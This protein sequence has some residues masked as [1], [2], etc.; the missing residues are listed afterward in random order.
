MSVVI[1]DD[2]DVRRG[3]SV[4]LYLPAWLSHVCLVVGYPFSCM[5]LPIFLSLCLPDCSLASCSLL[6]PAKGQAVASR[7][8][9]GGQKR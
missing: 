4:G 1:F 7:D 3:L 9:L 8:L 2:S 6:E 5:P